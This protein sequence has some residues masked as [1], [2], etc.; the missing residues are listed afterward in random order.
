[1][2]TLAALPAARAFRIPLVDGTI[3]EANIPSHQGRVK[4]WTLKWADRVIANSHVGLKAF[5][6]SPERGRVVHNGFD[7]ER[8]GACSGITKAE[9]VCTVI[10]V[11]R[12]QP[13]KDYATFIQ[14]ARILTDKGQDWR[15]I[16]L[17][18]GALRD[19]VETQAKDLAKSGSFSFPGP[20]LEVIPFVARADIGVLMTSRGIEEGISN[21]IME[22]MACGLPVICSDSG[23]NRELVVDGQTGFIIDSGNVQKLAEKLIWLREHPDAAQKMGLAGKERILHEFSV[24]GLVNGALDVYQELM[25]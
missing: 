2:S 9:D 10:M 15:F 21:A 3:R 17:G 14:A 5:G 6:I 8:L 22:Y 13:E 1:M 18:A 11:G 25:R 4:R 23:G 19:S 24:E 20:T 16:A 7:L 12:M